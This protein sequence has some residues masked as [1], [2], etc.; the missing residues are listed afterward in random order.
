MTKPLVRLCK[1]QLGVLLAWLWL[2]FG[3][4][5]WTRKMGL[6]KQGV[7]KDLGEVLQMF[8]IAILAGLLCAR[9][10]KQIKIT[11]NS[12][13]LSNAKS[14]NVSPRKEE[15]HSPTQEHVGSYKGNL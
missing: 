8:P 2:Q 7:S 1:Q 15:S 14:K 12:L 13:L 3:L 9:R 10:K 4:R 11:L 6:P 5:G